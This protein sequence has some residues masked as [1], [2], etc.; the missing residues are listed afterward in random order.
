MLPLCSSVPAVHR[1][2]LPCC[3]SSS[4]L[5]CCSLSP[6]LA[7]HLPCLLVFPAVRCPLCALPLPFGIHW[8]GR[9]LSW[10]HRRQHLHLPLRAVARRQGGGAV[11]W[12]PWC[13]CCCCCCLGIKP[14][15]TLRAEA[16]SGDVGVWRVSCGMGGVMIKMT[17][18]MKKKHVVSKR[19][20]E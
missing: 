6:L 7:H 13:R 11:M 15:A 9:L 16:R 4:T 19:K 10:F 18:K 3:R 17:L 14:I 12:R 20:K 8:R 1:S 5:A 2:S